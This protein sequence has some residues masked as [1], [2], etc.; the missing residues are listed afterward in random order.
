M[1][2][3]L[4]SR[5]FPPINAV[6][7]ERTKKLVRH[8]IRQRHA[9]T[10]FTVASNSDTSSSRSSGQ[11]IYRSAQLF[12]EYFLERKNGEK[13]ISTR[14]FFPG[15]VTALLDD[16]GWAWMSGLRRDLRRALIEE[17]RPDLVV[18]TG[19]PFLTFH[20]VSSFCLAESIPLVLDYRDPWSA[21][22]H[23]TYD[24]PIRRAFLR[25]LESR[26]NRNAAAVL[27]V[28]HLVGQALVDVRAPLLVLYNLPDAGYAQEVEQ[29]AADAPPLEKQ[30]L[31]LC[32]AGTLYPGRDL[33][34]LCAALKRLS[35]TDRA[36]IVLHYCGHSGAIAEASFRAHGLET[37]L[38][39]HG[40]LPKNRAIQLVASSDIALS[41]IA[42][43]DDPSNDA[44]RGVITTKI[45]D[46]LILG[47]EVL[48][49]VPA[50]FE[51]T[52]LANDLKINGLCNFDP[53]KDD[54][55]ADYLLLRI[56]D[57]RAGTQIAPTQH[58]DSQQLIR[59]WEAQ[60]RQLDTL[61]AEITQ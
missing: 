47:K 7:V 5:A 25:L 43:R 8:L 11:R 12:P 48:N 40:P 14:R 59:A 31:N 58:T 55:I 21:N 32:F 19:R 54:A 26:V 29:L 49:L 27:T 24:N 38:L 41:I 22:P 52:A 1:K 34:P 56:R 44:L 23:A 36:Q 37:L 9:I 2:V 30:R 57:K 16:S 50:G 13:F 42:S 46:Y 35:A 20:T 33:E 53:A 10:V 17:G 4:I 6:G 45:F 28:S 18:A 60:M 61:I 3:W 51:F 39:N 15:I